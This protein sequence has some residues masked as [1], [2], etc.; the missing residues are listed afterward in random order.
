MRHLLLAFTIALAACQPRTSPPAPLTRE[1]YV[2]QRISTPA[3]ASA[4]RRAAPVIDTFHI[5]AADLSFREKTPR[6]IR[7]GI[8]WP[9]L[10]SLS[11]PIGL[12]IRIPYAQNG[13][14]SDPAHLAEVSALIRSLQAESRAAGVK[15]SEIQIDYDSPASKLPLYASFLRSLVA[16]HRKTAITFTALPSW[17]DQP[18]LRDLAR[19]TRSYTLQVHSLDIPDPAHLPPVLCDIPAARRAISRASSF[20][21]PFRLA[22]PTYTS[23]VTLSPEGRISIFSENDPPLPHGDPSGWKI[24]RVS[25]DP[26]A[27]ASFVRELSASP[28]PHLTGIVWYRLP[29]D[30]DRRNWPWPAFLAVLEGRPP[31]SQLQSIL[32]PDSTG[33]TLISIQNTGETSEPPP[34]VVTLAYPPVPGVTADAL[35]PYLLLPDGSFQLR[36]GILP[37]DIPP[38]QSL[39]VGWIRHPAPETLKATIK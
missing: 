23:L 26:S 38:G 19:A 11:R 30:T 5:Q 34:P 35:G 20:G 12:V 1:A 8:P 37:L 32:A 10:A 4:I 27:L 7:T 13:L 2:W 18:V 6:L 39:P 16:A 9:V 14:G 3:L 25:A 31:R 29:I 17:L 21:I 33:A 15:V 36:E 24:H 22:L 28:P